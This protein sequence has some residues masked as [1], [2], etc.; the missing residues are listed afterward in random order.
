MLQN[1]RALVSVL[2]ILWEGHTQIQVKG[3]RVCNVNV[4]NPCMQ[5]VKN[6]FENKRVCLKVN[7]LITVHILNY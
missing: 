3:S 6:T 7:T 2:E 4:H 5:D 1:M